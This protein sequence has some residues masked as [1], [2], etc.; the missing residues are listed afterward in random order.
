MDLFTELINAFSMSELEKAREILNKIALDKESID[1]LA[2]E[3]ISLENIVSCNL[4]YYSN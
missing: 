4:K 2:H 3:G 1:E